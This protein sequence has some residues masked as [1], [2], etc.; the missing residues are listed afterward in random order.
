MAIF[1]ELSRKKVLK[2]PK[3]STPGGTIKRLKKAMADSNLF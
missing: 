3:S 2:R 1:D